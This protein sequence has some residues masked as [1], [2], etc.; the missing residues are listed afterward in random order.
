MLH[1]IVLSLADLNAVQLC[2]QWR[3]HLGGKAPAHLPRWLLLRVLAYRLQATALGDLDKATA[4]IIR[5]SQG[6][7]IDFSGNSFRRAAR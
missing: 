1:A 3:N 5:A 4:R 2:L 7:A 6:G